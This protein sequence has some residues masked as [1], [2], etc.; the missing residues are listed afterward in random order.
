MSHLL[1]KLKVSWVVV[2]NTI[3]ILASLATIFTL[4]M[5]SLN[6]IKINGPQY[7]R[8]K[9]TSDLIADVAPPPLFVVEAHLDVQELS[10]ATEPTEI[11]HFQDELGRLEKEAASRAEFWQQQEIPAE[12][13]KF[14]VDHVIAGGK[15]FFTIVDEKLIPSLKLHAVKEVAIAQQEIDTLYDAHKT[16]IAQLNKMLN[17]VQ[18]DAEATANATE[19]KNLRDIHTLAFGTAFVI[20]LLGGLLFMCLRLI[21]N[22]AHRFKQMLDELPINVMV[23]DPK[24]A[25]I[26][27]ANNTSVKTLTPLEQYLPIKAAQLIGTNIDVFHKN[28]SHQRAILSDPTRLP[29]QAKIKVG[30]E[31]LSLR[32]SAIRDA[33]GHY[34]TA[35]LT[36]AVITQQEN[37]IH[38]FETGVA[39]SVNTVG[40]AASEMHDL[41]GGMRQASGKAV[42][43][44]TQVASAATQVN[45]NVETVAAAAEEL[46]ASIAEITRQIGTTA[47]L[48]KNAVVQTQRSN[49]TIEQLSVAAERI[50]SVT[51]LISRVAEK[52]NLLALNATIEAARAGESGKGFAVVAVEVKNLAAQT[53]KATEDIAAQI[54]AIQK[55]TAATVIDVR[56]VG[57][58]I[59]KISEIASTVAAAAEEQGAATQE[60][61]RNIQEAA[62]GTKQVN[63]SIESVSDASNETGNS[64]ESVLR[65]AVSVTTQS[66]LM[67]QAV[68]KFL[69][70]VKNS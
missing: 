67:R 37:M 66:E 60:I 24:T 55:A 44:S 69:K 13:K 43:L 51:E 59:S 6:E 56:E 53:A 58:T 62:T 3:L 41:A 39:E 54:A 49:E 48:A 2:F 30:P 38:E 68:D 22:E 63:Q 12:V 10:T 61:S 42:Q 15:K 19:Q 20:I 40:T 34:L 14:L 27:Y 1:A 16:D 64:A 52:T 21:L 45:A 32:I 29:W 23:A 70:T 46:N 65:A 50:G 11:R 17:K 57:Q 36:W 28:P 31:T 33:T 25:I 9:T 26:T 7:M 5:N 35:M 8:L 18:E 47:S 4:F